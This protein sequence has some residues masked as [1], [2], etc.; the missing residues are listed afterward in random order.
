VT[1]HDHHLPWEKVEAAQVKAAATQLLVH[2]EILQSVFES[3]KQVR[4]HHC[5]FC[6]AFHLYEVYGEQ[7]AA[8]CREP[9]ERKMP[10]YP[11]IHMRSN[12]HCTNEPFDVQGI[13][14]S[15]EYCLSVEVERIHLR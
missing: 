2:C 3:L 14:F 9:E 12:I 11:W 8:D 4:N 7:W 6:C 15:Y 13:L 5:C 1:I 10:P